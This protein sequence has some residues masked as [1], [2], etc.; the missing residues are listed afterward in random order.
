M[1]RT[2]ASFASEALRQLK[3]AGGEV[4]DLF[5]RDNVYDYIRKYFGAFHTM[6]EKLVFDDIDAYIAR[7]VA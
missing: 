2:I 5:A 3:F 4:A 1:H 6:G 7:Q